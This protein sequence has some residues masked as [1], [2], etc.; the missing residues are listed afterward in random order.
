MGQDKLQ[1]ATNMM[2]MKLNSMHKVRIRKGRQVWLCLR[3]IDSIIFAM[4]NLNI[5][6]GALGYF[7]FR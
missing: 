3:S 1:D 7:R 2:G 5:T 6:P 4:F